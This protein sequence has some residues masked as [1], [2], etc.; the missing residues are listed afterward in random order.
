M[1]CPNAIMNRRWCKTMSTP[2]L[3]FEFDSSLFQ[4]YYGS[5]INTPGIYAIPEDETEPASPPEE[6]NYYDAPNP[7]ADDGENTVL[8]Q[9]ES[10]KD[11]IVDTMSSQQD[12][13]LPQMSA[14]EQQ[15]Y[16]Q[17]IQPIKKVFLLNKLK[18]LQKILQDSSLSDDNLNIVLKYGPYLTYP[19]LLRLAITAI[20]F[21][22]SNMQYQ[23][24]RDESEEKNSSA[25]EI[26]QQMDISNMA[27]STGAD[28]DVAAQQFV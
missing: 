21:L 17:E 7:A 5:G 1:T 23:Q 16:E 18:K 19:T 26:Q 13:P 2:F 24:T 9:R 14:D 22:K 3:F 4:K 25:S 27:P 20:N 11:D 15:A 10:I 6:Q 28:V 12:I 8:S